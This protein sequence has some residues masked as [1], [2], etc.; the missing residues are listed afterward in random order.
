MSMD[1]TS[2]LPNDPPV[3]PPTDPPVDP[4]VTPPLAPDPTPPADP[5][6][7]MID[8]HPDPIVRENTRL[9]ETKSQHDA[10]AQ[11]VEREKYLGAKGVIPPREGDPEDL[12]RFYGELPQQYRRPD[13]AEDYNLGEIGTREDVPWDAE[14]QKKMVGVMWDNNATESLVQNVLATYADAAGAAMNVQ[15]EQTKQEIGRL[16]QDL[17]DKWADKFNANEDYAKRVIAAFPDDATALAEVK[18][19]G[20]I[21]LAE[22]PSMLDFLVTIG[23]RLGE[24][25]M[26]G[27]SKNVQTFHMSPEDATKRIEALRAEPHYMEDSL[28]GKQL[29]AEIAELRR[30]AD[31]GDDGEFPLGV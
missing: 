30:L 7:Q 2:G 21:P 29:S 23:K 15:A 31:P 14:L 28:R 25:G 3:A 27:G 1:P 9:R 5:W 17:V 18:L 4:G 22:H 19:E 6:R 8:S 12:N 10:M 13:T 16:S 26:K 24:H 20:G 11:F